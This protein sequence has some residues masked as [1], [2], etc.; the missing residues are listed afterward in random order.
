MVLA[1]VFP[2]NINGVRGGGASS[3]EFSSICSTTVPTAADGGDPFPQWSPSCLPRR[4]LDRC[5]AQIS[6]SASHPRRGAFCRGTLQ[7]HRANLLWHPGSREGPSCGRG[8]SSITP[9]RFNVRALRRRTARVPLWCNFP[10]GREHRPDQYGQSHGP[11][12]KMA[13]QRVRRQDDLLLCA[14]GGGGRQCGGSTSHQEKECPKSKWAKSSRWH[15]Q[16]FRAAASCTAQS[17]NSEEANSSI[18]GQQG[19][20]D[21]GDLANPD[22]SAAVLSRSARAHGISGSGSIPGT[23]CQSHN[24]VCTA[25]SRGKHARISTPGK[26]GSRPSNL[27]TRPGPPPR[28]RNQPEMAPTGDLR[29][30][31]ED[32]PNTYEA[33]PASPLQDHYPQALIA[34]SAEQVSHIHSFQT[35]PMTELAGAAPSIGVK[36][37][38]GRE[39]L[40]RELASQSGQF[41]LRVCQNIQRSMDPAGKKEGGG[42]SLTNYYLERIG[43]HG[44]SRELGLVMRHWHMSSTM[45]RRETF[46]QCRTMWPY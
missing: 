37:S 19:R 27:S 4:R 45:P 20:P 9:G 35:G 7:V 22:S 11:G 41:Y 38:M 43:G 6:L 8:R 26:T 14:R 46:Q 32:E 29:T 2:P 16:R 5:Y 31:P 44:Q 13:C 40:Q 23:S 21:Y 34:Q 33:D 24:S 18:F 28:T 25:N 30:F 42:T 10:G 12:Q 17:P 3:G 36:G 15:Y 39:K 1:S